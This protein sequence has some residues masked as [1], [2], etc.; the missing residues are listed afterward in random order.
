MTIAAP[1]TAPSRAD[2]PETFSAKA[3]AFVLWMT[4]QLVPG[5]NAWLADYSG[6]SSASPALAANANFLGNWSSGTAYTVPSSVYHSGAVWI[7]LQSST[8][9]TPADG[10]AYWARID[11]QHSLPIVAMGSGTAIDCTLGQVFSR[12][13]AGNVTFSISGAPSNRAFSVTLLL[14]HTSGVIT[15]PTPFRWPAGVAPNL[16]TGRT[17]VV[18]ALTYDAGANWLAS[19]IPNYTVV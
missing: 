10:S 3:D 7:A 1:P 19:A 6:L 12:T 16:L 8:N 2:A 9:Q 13:V 5:L 4:S 14:V 18:T 15:W 11:F 17:H